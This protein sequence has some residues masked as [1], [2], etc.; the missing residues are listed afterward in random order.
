MEINIE[1]R[2]RENSIERMFSIISRVDKSKNAKEF[3]NISYINTPKNVRRLRIAYLMNHSRV[4]GGV[5]ILLEHTDALSKN[6]HEVFILSRDPKPEWKEIKANYIHISP[7]TSFLENLPEVDVIVCTVADQMPE[8]FLSQ[9]APCILFEQG[10]VYIYEYDSLEESRKEFYR[11]IWSLPVPIVAVSKAL[12]DKLQQNFNRNSYILHNALDRQCFFS[13]DP[14]HNYNSEPVN[15]LFVG[16]ED[17]HFKGI[18]IIREALRIVRNTGRDFNEIWVTQNTPNSDFNGTLVVNPSQRELGNVYRNCD[19]FVSGSFYESFPLPPLEAM[20]CGCAVIS[21]DNL[22]IKEYGVDGYNCLLGSIGDPQS[23]ATKIIKLLDNQE[24]R[25]ELVLNGYKT[26]E[27]YSWEKVISIW[28]DYLFGAISYWNKSYVNRSSSLEVITLPATL[29]YYEAQERIDES[30]RNMK[31]EWIFFLIEGEV[32]NK[33]SQECLNR[34]INTSLFNQYK[35]NVIYPDVISGHSIVLKENRVFKKGQTEIDDSVYCLPLEI[36]HGSEPYFQSRWLSEVKLNYINSKF[37]NCIHLIK[38]QFQS[39]SSKEQLVATKWLLLTLIELDKYE[40]IIKICNQSIEQDI[41]YSDIL[42][43]FAR[44]C[45]NLNQ[46]DIARS[47]LITAKRIGSATHYPE[48]FI[49]M[50]GLCDM[51]LSVLDRK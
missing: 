40:D 20:T 1:H 5:K 49:N 41:T 47:L 16:Q 30:R 7:H 9:K 37:D 12:K 8:V 35:I 50:S 33:E 26:A 32:F 18:K 17:N 21:T 39:L 11:K 25:K 36:N 19:I 31:S 42:Y 13:S 48:C 14:V 23:I 45:I 27:K 15:I 2:L 24:L 44:V 6:G 46:V 28:E 3:D 38:H 51:Y 34:V 43:L 10:D 29:N 4:C 22:G